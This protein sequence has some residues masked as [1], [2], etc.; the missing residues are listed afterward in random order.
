[1]NEDLLTRF[2]LP[3]AG[4]RGVHVR[5]HRSW[6]ELLSH[7][8]YPPGARR[9]LGEACAGAAL[10]TAHDPAVRDA[11]RALTLAESAAM[12]R[13]H[14]HILDTLA[15]AYWANGLIEEALA[16]EARAVR[17]DPRNRAYYL[18]QMETFR[19]RQWGEEP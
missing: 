4:V 18:R 6:L 11:G 15:T 16:T 13:E 9:L 3:H 1:M 12:A 14:G 17:L 19:T 7:A 8:D 10:L 2:L 5:L